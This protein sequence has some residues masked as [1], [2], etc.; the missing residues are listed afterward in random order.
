MEQFKGASVGVFYLKKMVGL[1]NVGERETFH[2]R[3]DL[4]A[5]SKE[6]KETLRGG[7]RL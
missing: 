2:R 6:A 5:G 3:E 1:V 7:R 4:W